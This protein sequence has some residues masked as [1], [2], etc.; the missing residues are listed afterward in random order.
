MEDSSGNEVARTS[1]GLDGRYLIA[2]TP[3][4][5]TLSPQKPA[6]NILPVASD[7]QVEVGVGQWV[8]AD[9]SYDTGIR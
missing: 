9:I 7:M 3:G 5:Y 4:T 1:S 8:V 2:L 6:D